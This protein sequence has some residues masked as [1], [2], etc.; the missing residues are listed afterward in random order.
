M[1]VPFTQSGCPLE[2]L[3]TTTPSTYMCKET[4]IAA[5][6]SELE[7]LKVGKNCEISRFC[8]FRAY[9][10]IMTSQKD[11]KYT[12]T[13]TIQLSIRPVNIKAISLKMSE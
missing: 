13:C 1:S 11:F 4:L 10:V 12:T 3:L 2:P 6:L 5:L 7:L 9:H 8:V